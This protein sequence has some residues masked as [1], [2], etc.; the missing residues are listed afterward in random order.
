MK[1]FNLEEAKAGKPLVTRAGYPVE[2]IGISKTHKQPLICV[3]DGCEE[4][5]NLDGTYFNYT[6]RKVSSLDLCMAP[7]NREGWVNVYPNNVTYLYLTQTIAE[8]NAGLDRIACVHVEW[9]E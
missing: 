2:F 8:N 7:T 4:A 5:Y 6:P 9:E 3:H 1:P